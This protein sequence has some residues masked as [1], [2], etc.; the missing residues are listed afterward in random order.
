MK[1]LCY[2]FVLFISINCYT[3]NN[4]KI[5]SLTTAINATENPVQKAKL[6]LKRSKLLT[7]SNVNESYQDA[8][9]TLEISKIQNEENLHLETLTQLSAV[10]F[11]QEKFE[12]ALDYDF[13]ALTLAQSLN[14]NLGIINTYKNISRNKK[15]LGNIKESILFAE[16]AKGI[17]IEKKLNQELA[18]INN[19]LGVAYRNNNDFQKSLSVLNEA[20]TQTKNLKLIALL[21]MNKANTLTELMRLDEAIENHLECLKINE[22]LNDSKGKQQTYNNLGVL[23]KKAKQYDKSIQY[24]HKSIKIATE[25]KNKLSVAIGYDNV[26]TAYDLMNKKDSILWYRK[27]A[28]AIFESINDEKNIARGYHNLGNYYLLHD[29]L[30][31]AEQNLLIALQKRIIINNTNDIA[32]T[33]TLLGKLYDNQQQFEKAET[34][35]NEAKQLYKTE[36]TDKK[37][38]F[39]E[40]YSNH[41][42]LKGDFEQALKIKEEQLIVRDS[43]LHKSEIINVIKKENDFVVKNQNKKIIK[44]QTIESNIKQSK[45]IYG[46]L[47]FLVFILALYSFVRWKKSDANKKKMQ[48]EKSLVERQ[49]VVIENENINIREELVNVKKLV[50]EDYIMLK[51]KTKIY[52]NELIYIKSED[53]YLEIYTQNKKEFLRGTVNEILIQLPPNFLQSHRSY[54]VNTNFIQGI[55]SSEIIL[56]NLIKLPLTRK[57]KDNFKE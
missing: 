21:K 43:L 38:E 50:F 51:N 5:D 4:S 13:Q 12:K 54:I 14:Q 26:A 53:H 47:I 11:V 17:A 40:A 2:L 32:S 3:Q 49:K 39:L 27:N 36:A 41:F 52:L 9:K 33:K 42:K 16:K 25:N 30:T 7:T 29:F 6:L 35:L 19:V 46:I 20:L 24:F 45:I 44:L 55:N 57:Y 23:F 31:E 8:I 34:Y 22:Q 10:L 15:A 37:A 56:K 1:Q 48:I 28:I 18:S